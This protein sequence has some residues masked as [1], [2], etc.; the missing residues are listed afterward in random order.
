MEVLLCRSDGTARE[1]RSRTLLIFV[2]SRKS[3]DLQLSQRRS[4]P[5][6]LPRP[7]QRTEVCSAALPP[8]F[9]ALLAAQPNSPLPQLRT[10]PVMAC[11][12]IAQGLRMQQPSLLLPHPLRS[13]SWSCHPRCC[14]S[15]ALR[16]SRSRSWRSGPVCQLCLQYR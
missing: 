16:L 4:A 12:V 13:A 10:H 15:P 3:L 1:T 6:L 8:I 11:L 9:M 5:S 7:F 14:L 2:F